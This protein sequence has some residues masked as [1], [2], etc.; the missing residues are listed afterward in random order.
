MSLAKVNAT[1]VTGTRNRIA[2]VAPYSGICAACL[3]GCPGFCEVAKSGFRGREILY[4]QPYGEITAGAQK[5]YP[6]DYS[7]FNIQGTCVGAI[8]M[9]ADSDKAI[10]NDV[11][12]QIEIGAINKMKLKTPIFTGALG[13]TDIARVNWEHLAAGAAISGILL[14]VGENVCGMDP[15]SEF[16]NG[17]VVNSPELKRRIDTYKKW[18]EGYGGILVQ[19]NVEDGRIGT[20]KLAIDL[21]ADGIEIKWGQGAKDIGGEVKLPTLER[22]KQLKGR[23]YIVFPNPDD[24]MFQESFKSG[25]FRKF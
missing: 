2:D 12:I 21:G 22:A 19:H 25:A 1:A 5:S 4:P 13:S 23:G 14:V 6:V 15:N 20:P 9:P 24:R 3:D 7:H 10:F 17:T 8:G 16:R 11:N 18:Y